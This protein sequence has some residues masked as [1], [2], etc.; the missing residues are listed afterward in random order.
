[1]NEEFFNSLII[2]DHFIRQCAERAPWFVTAKKEKYG[3]GFEIELNRLKHAVV[4]AEEIKR[5]KTISRL[6]KYG[7]K[8]K[9]YHFKETSLKKQVIFVIEGKSLVTLYLYNKSWAVNNG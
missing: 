3:G 1:M 4:M 2:S 9:Y 7:D 8:T 5:F 6:I